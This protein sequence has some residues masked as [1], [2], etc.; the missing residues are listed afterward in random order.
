MMKVIAATAMWDLY[1]FGGGAWFS[2]GG[3]GGLGGSSTTFTTT[4]ESLERFA[5]ILKREYLYTTRMLSR[6]IISM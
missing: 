1:V 4:F 2:K 6:S 3:L 5:Y